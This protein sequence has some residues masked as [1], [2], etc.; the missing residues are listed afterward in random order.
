MFCEV[1]ETCWHMTIWKLP[2]WNSKQTRGK[3]LDEAV[4]IAVEMESTENEINYFPSDKKVIKVES[5]EFFRCGKQNNWPDKCF[6][7]NSECHIC[8]KKGQ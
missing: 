3:L 6:Y 5:Q 4:D 7:K 8:K 1:A 2:R